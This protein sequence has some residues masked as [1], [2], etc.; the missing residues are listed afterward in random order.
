LVRTRLL[1]G[2]F[3]HSGFSPHGP[4]LWGCRVLL[5]SSVGLGLRTF[6]WCSWHNQSC[7]K[8]HSST[9]ERRANNTD[10]AGRCVESLPGFDKSNRIAENG[11]GLNHFCQYGKGNLAVS[12]R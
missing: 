11:T 9:S 8:F 5:V 6:P 4:I 2:R 10:A 3:H 12:S 1:G 7:L